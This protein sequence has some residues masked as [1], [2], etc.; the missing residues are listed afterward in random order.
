M[1]KSLK[2]LFAKPPVE[3]QAMLQHRLN[4]ATAALLIEMSRADYMVARSE[5]RTLAV[6]LHAALGL[7]KDEIL[8]LIALAGEAANKANSLSELTQ[9]INEHCEHEQKLL[10][11][12]SMWRVALVD[13]NLDVYEERLIRQV[14]DLI[15]VPNTDYMRMKVIAGG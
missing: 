5:E 14:S 10:L 9:L 12:Q 7:E 11:I 4:L 3:D 15:N 13:D 1:I 8:E 2:S 6:I